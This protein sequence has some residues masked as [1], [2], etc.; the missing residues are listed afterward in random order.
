MSGTIE[1]S[2]WG[3]HRCKPPLSQGQTPGDRTEAPL[4]SIWRCSDCGT[5]YMADLDRWG[6]TWVRIRRPREFMAHRL[7]KGKS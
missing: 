2:G 5:R 7:R 1:R 6:K 4:G 3:E